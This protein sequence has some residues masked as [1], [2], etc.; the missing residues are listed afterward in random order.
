MSNKNNQYTR[1]WTK[2]DVQFLIDNYIKQGSHYCAKQL[3]RT[4]N[5]IFH[6]ASRLGL[7]RKGKGR[8]ERYYMYDGYI[9][10]SRFN[11]RKFVHRKVM[12]SVLGRPL[13]SWEIVHHIDGDKLNNDPKNLQLTTRSEH[14]LLH[15][16]ER[17][18]LGQFV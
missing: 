15:E 11:E 4:Q 16:K 8:L 3:N 18:E 12:E 14:M 7:K 5:S 6:K 9:C 17:N 13:E 10:V 1:P 2:E